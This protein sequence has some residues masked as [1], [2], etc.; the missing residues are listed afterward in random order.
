VLWA[1]LKLS[2]QQLAPTGNMAEIKST[3]GDQDYYLQF[4][5]LK[6]APPANGTQISQGGTVGTIGGTGMSTGK[7]AHF[8]VYTKTKPDVLHKVL[9]HPPEGPVY[10]VNPMYF[11]NYMV[12]P[13]KMEKPR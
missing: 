6:G 10:Y 9:L 12:A 7:H 13:R 11:L 1:K 5:H 3:I 8:G 4:M 2:G